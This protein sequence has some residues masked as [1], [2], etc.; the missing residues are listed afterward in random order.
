MGG[1]DHTGLNGGGGAVGGNESPDKC[2]ADG[3]ASGVGGV[4]GDH[5]KGGGDPAC[6]PLY[7]LAIIK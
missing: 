6:R 3:K 7:L 4:G 2:G 5:G 1:D